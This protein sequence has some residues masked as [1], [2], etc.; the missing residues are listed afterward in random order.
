M[1]ESFRQCNYIFVFYIVKKVYKN[2][3]IND[4][5]KKLVIILMKWCV[6]HCC[7]SVLKK[8]RI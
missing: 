2:H 1:D 7:M 3:V 8:K 5:E 4:E 6:I